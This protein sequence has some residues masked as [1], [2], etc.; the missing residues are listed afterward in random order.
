MRGIAVRR[1]WAETQLVHSFGGRQLPGTPDGMFE[2]WDGNLTC[3]QVVR[4]PIS[5]HMTATQVEETLYNV[6][7]TKILKSQAWMKASGTL[8][9]EFVIFCWV[10]PVAEGW[11]ESGHNCARAQELVDRMKL[12]GWPFYLKVME[13]TEPGALFPS[14]FAF[15]HT[16][17]EC[18]GKQRK[19][20]VSEADLSTFDPG[21]FDSDVEEEPF[22]WDIFAFDPDSASSCSSEA[23]CVDTRPSADW[24][25]LTIQEEDATI[26]TEQN[27]EEDE[28]AVTHITNE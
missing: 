11:L 15:S 19:S 25:I 23:S 7:L 1:Q 26:E 5:P 10:P 17:R 6:V 20:S 3:V 18:R 24:K 8:P 21:D 27:V 9:H 22:E 13:P 14:K 2:D 12:E 16:G 28:D 4:V